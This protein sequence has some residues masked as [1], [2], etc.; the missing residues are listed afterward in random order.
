[1]SQNAGAKKK[2]SLQPD[3]AS[4]FAS[5]SQ[6]VDEIPTLADDE[7]QPC[8][9]HGQTAEKTESTTRPNADSPHSLDGMAMREPVSTSPNQPSNFNF[10]N[11]MFGK[12]Q[13]SF[14]PQ[15]FKAFSWLHYL[16]YNDTVLCHTCVTA[17]EQRK[18]GNAKN[19]EKAFLIN[20]FS[21]WKKALEKFR[22]HQKSQCHKLAVQSVELPQQCGDIGERLDTALAAEKKWNRSILVKIV[23]NLRLMGRQGLSLQG[24]TDED[25]NFIQILKLRAI[26]DPSIL[27]WLEKK[28]ANIPPMISKMSY[29]KS[30]PTS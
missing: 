18:L 20:G 5:K 3:I 6:R 9:S 4:F 30:W 22:D 13:R 17:D 7:S 26:D 16:E 14:Q 10:P 25:S 27:K 29:S 15:W 28:L 23:E 11:R 24:S 2:R 1:M 19:A 21:N 12:Q 8:T